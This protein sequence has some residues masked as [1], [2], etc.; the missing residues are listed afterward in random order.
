MKKLNLPNLDVIAKGEDLD[1][2]ELEGAK[3]SSDDPIDIV[4]LRSM[5]SGTVIIDDNKDKTKSGG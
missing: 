5:A 1:L 2:S 3:A 4:K